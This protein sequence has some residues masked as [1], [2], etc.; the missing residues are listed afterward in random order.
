[1]N[2]P[3]TTRLSDMLEVVPGDKA[4]IPRAQADN[5]SQEQRFRGYRRIRAQAEI[6]PISRCDDQL[7]NR[8]VAAHPGHDRVGHYLRGHRLLSGF[9]M[10]RQVELHAHRLTRLECL[11]GR[12]GE[13]SK[14]E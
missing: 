1:M 8:D 2:W 14:G 3:T 4:A 10:F 6:S 11:G 9:G 12:Q 5:S 13:N 7:S